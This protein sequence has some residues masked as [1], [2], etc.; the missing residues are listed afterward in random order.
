[1]KVLIL[2]FAVLV[3]AAGNR[4]GQSFGNW[5]INN[6]LLFPILSFLYSWVSFIG[7]WAAL[8]GHYEWG[9]ERAL[10]WYNGKLGLPFAMNYPVTFT[11]A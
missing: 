7:F 9:V 5:F 6:F 1:M 4:F 11:A 10:K 2:L 8:F 3:L